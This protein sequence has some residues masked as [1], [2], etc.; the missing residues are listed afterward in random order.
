VMIA[1]GLD[2]IRRKLDPGEP[3]N[4]NIFE[5]SHREK[6][7]LRIDELP[8]DLNDAVRAMKKDDVV[9]EA[10]GDHIFDHFV[11]AKL[12]TWRD[13]SSAVHPWEIDRYLARY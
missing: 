2:G 4:R 1:S 10:L 12:A 13:F 3:V 6:R 11:E 5:M 9:R 7:R 8:T